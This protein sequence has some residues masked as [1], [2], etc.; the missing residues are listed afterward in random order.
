MRY[1]NKFLTGDST[2]SK[3]MGKPR[4]ELDQAWHELLDST[5]IR[6]SEEELLLANNTTSVPHKDGGHLGGL[7]ISHTMHCLVSVLS[8]VLFLLR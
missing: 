3:F 2:S 8:L 1:I 7:G 4:P 5:M 6:Y